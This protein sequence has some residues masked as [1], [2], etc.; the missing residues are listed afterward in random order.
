MAILK[1]IE[2]QR[3]STLFPNEPSG[4]CVRTQHSNQYRRSDQTVC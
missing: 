2:V 1:R 4:T 3:T